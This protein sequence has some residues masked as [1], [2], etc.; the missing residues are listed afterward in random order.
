MSPYFI[1]WNINEKHIIA[2]AVCLDSRHW[3]RFLKSFSFVSLRGSWKFNSFIQT[4]GC[5][6]INTFNRHPPFIQNVVIEPRPISFFTIR[7]MSC[8]RRSDHSSN[9]LSNRPEDLYL[10]ELQSKGEDTHRHC[11]NNIRQWC[12][13]IVLFLRRKSP[14]STHVLHEFFGLNLK[15]IFIIN[16]W[17]EY[18]HIRTLSLSY[19]STKASHSA[20]SRNSC[21]KSFACN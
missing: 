2:A 9:R 10:N 20:F 7:I 21:F 4:P 19:F 15:Y 14:L 5:L 8:V 16:I 13:K 6:D 3:I 1:Q 17:T 11:I 12:S 18:H